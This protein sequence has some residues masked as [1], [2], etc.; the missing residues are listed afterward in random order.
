MG[1]L[2]KL[3]LLPYDP[4]ELGSFISNQIPSKGTISEKFLNA[5]VHHS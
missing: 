3:A 2:L 5:A 4:N 1:V